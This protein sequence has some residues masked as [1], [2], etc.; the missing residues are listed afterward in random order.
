MSYKF[1]GHIDWLSTDT[2]VGDIFVGL[3]CRRK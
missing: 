2:G 3:Y 1:V